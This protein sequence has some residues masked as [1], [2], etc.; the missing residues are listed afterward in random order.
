M[1]RKKLQAI[2][3]E[4]FK[5]LIFE[6]AKKMYAELTGG[7]IEFIAEYCGKDPEDL[8]PVKEESDK[9]DTK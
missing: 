5:F 7:K 2:T 8:K 3:E 4:N 9:E 6:E 1:E